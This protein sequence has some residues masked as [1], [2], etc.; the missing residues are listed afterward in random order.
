[1]SMMRNDMAHWRKEPFQKAI[2]RSLEQLL[3]SGSRITKQAVIDGAYFDNGS[4]VGKTTLYSR[5]ERTGQLVHADLLIEIDDAA[6][7]QRKRKKG[8]TRAESLADMGR[9]I[10][11][12]KDENAKLI[13]QVV[14][15]E[16]KLSKEE[17]SMDGERHLICSQETEMYVLAKVAD[18]LAQGV[19]E[20]FRRLTNRIEQKYWAD[21]RLG[22]ATEEA[23]RYLEEVQFSRLVGL[24]GVRMPK[25]AEKSRNL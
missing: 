9:Q 4:S 23:M 20:D 19:V 8:K 21:E 7:S 24:N 14:E 18:E 15:Q 25:K 1:M 17:R 5:H 13:D 10:K 22:L 16:A 2:R 6:E 11:Q 3:R 12:L